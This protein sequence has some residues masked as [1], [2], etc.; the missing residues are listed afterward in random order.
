M[1]SQDHDF[2]GR[3][4]ELAETSQGLASPN[5]PVGCVIVKDGQVV[6][7][8]SHA[9]STRDHAE[10]R[11]LAEAGSRAAGATVYVT[12]EPC[13]HFGRTPPC[14]GAL[15]SAGVRRVVLARLDPNPAVSGAGI[16]ALR[17]AGLDVDVGIGHEA[18]GRL[19]EP[20]ACHVTTGL[21]LVVGKA[22]MSLDGRIA[23]SG[24]PGGWITSEEARDCGQKLR[25]QLDAI[26]V[27]IGTILADDPRLTYRGTLPKARPLTAVVLDSA[28]RTPTGARLF[29]AV[30]ARE[31]LIFSREDASS[32]ARRPLEDRGAEIIPTA[33]GPHGLDLGSILRELG[34]RK[35][36]GVLVEG[37]SEVHGSFFSADLFDKFYFMVAPIVIGGK[38]S[39]PAVGGAGFP[40]ASAAPHLRILR[41]FHAG[42]DLILEA[43]PSHSRSI[44]SPWLPS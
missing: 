12:L 5:P 25:L 3:A 10:V 40:S 8:G 23:V 6:G 19:I 26:L 34:T 2:M 42:P 4:L 30:P 29:D 9:Y 41:S 17:A 28:L 43:Y 15:I 37:G 31:I 22:G 36:L 18:A 24:N 39:V 27:G 38:K 33:H 20:F 11:A 16:A 1:D 21:P 13:S 7:A 44:L 35:K 32:A 14:A